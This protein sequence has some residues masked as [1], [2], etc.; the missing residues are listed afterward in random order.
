MIAEGPLCRSW[1]RVMPGR[2]MTDDVER[3]QPWPRVGHTVRERHKP[4]GDPCIRPSRRDTLPPRQAALAAD[5]QGVLRSG[6]REG[7]RVPPRE[8][9]R[10]SLA[11]L[12]VGDTFGEQF[13]GDTQEVVPRIVGRVVPRPP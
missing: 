3:C 5:W 11:G 1:Q 7:D 6:R 13:F 12:S 4:S 10:L 2:G 9:A 8:R